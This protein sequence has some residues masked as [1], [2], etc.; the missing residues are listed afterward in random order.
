MYHILLCSQGYS[1]SRISWVL[2]L[3]MKG[4]ATVSKWLCL[5]VTYI[6]ER[7]DANVAISLRKLWGSDSKDA[8]AHLFNWWQ[9]GAV[10]FIRATCLVPLFGQIKT[11]RLNQGANGYMIHFICATESS[12]ATNLIPFLAFIVPFTSYI[13]KRAYLEMYSG[14]PNY[15]GQILPKTNITTSS[16]ILYNIIIIL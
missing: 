3:H 7:V 6:Q 9:G 8:G 13:F 1:Y 11:S 2:G 14:L 16:Q 10:L 15:Q 12:V 5:K 4:F